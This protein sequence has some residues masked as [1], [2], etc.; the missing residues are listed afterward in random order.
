MAGKN[1]RVGVEFSRHKEKKTLEITVPCVKLRRSK[2]KLRYWLVDIE[3][4]LDVVVDCDGMQLRPRIVL[5]IY[6]QVP[7]KHRQL[8]LHRLAMDRLGQRNK[9]VALPPH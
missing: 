7:Q 6:C 5:K 4:P 3:Q 8:H 1:P 2:N 9:P